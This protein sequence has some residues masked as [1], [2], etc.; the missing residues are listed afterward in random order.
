MMEPARHSGSQ[1]PLR[2]PPVANEN[3]EPEVMLSWQWSLF[4]ELSQYD[5]LEIL[6]VRQAVFIVEQN[7][8]YQ[9]VDDLDPVSWHLMGWHSANAEKKLTAYLRVVPPGKKY[10]EPSLGR[11]LTVSSSR[12]IGSGRA[13]LTEGISRTSL[14]YQGQGIRISAQRYLE[15]FYSDFRFATVSD[16]YDEDGI[17]HVEMLRDA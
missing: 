17:P 1:S 3:V 8:P 5:L 2:K 4:S 11:V 12:G 14:A 15:P 9:D 16:I 13:L 7:C 10:P 6:K